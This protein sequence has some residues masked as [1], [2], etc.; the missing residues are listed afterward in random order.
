MGNDT[1]DQSFAATIG[2]RY[3]IAI[4]KDD[5]FGNTQT[6]LNY[7]FDRFRAM[8]VRELRMDMIWMDVQP[9]NAVP[10]WT[11]W[12]GS[13]YVMVANTAAA[14][15]LDLIF[16]VH[17]T[18]SWARL[19]GANYNGPSDPAAYAAFCAAVATHFTSAGRRL[20]AIEVWNEPNLSGSGTFWQYGRPAS[21][22]AAMQIAAHAAVKALPGAAGQVLVGMGGLSAVP[23]T[24]GDASFRYTAA[25]EWL[26]ALY[27][28]S[29]WAA[30]NDFLAVHPYTYPFPWADG[31]SN[32]DGFEVLT[33]LRALAVAQ[34]ES[35]K[36]WWLTEYGAPTN[37][38]GAAVTQEEQRQ[39][40]LDL[41]DWTAQ[42]ENSW[43]TKWHWYSYYD[44]AAPTSTDP[45]H[46]FGIYLNDELAEKLVPAAMRTIRVGS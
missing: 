34:G 12:P 24:G 31:V 26:T 1:A 40:F 30:A 38:A 33:Q 16:C 20:I 28:V 43:V 21:Q 8:G 42:P 23:V 29:G 14:Y 32:N 17:M 9:T 13:E 36:P 15:G 35:A 5:I 2:S 27:A 39:M 19:S 46:G 45:E 18:P 10:N 11:T 22:L 44:R 37:D 25:A 4:P 6:Q 7:I 3:G 41:F